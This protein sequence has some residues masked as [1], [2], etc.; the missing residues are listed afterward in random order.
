MEGT[1]TDSAGLVM[2]LPFMNECLSE[3]LFQTGIFVSVLFL[4]A[5]KAA[6]ELERLLVSKEITDTRGCWRTRNG[7]IWV[8]NPRLRR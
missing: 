3:S 7:G 8:K 5:A 6:T 4:S 2:A 1:D